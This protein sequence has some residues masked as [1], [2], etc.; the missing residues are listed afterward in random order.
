MHPLQG[1]LPVKV[2]Y[3]PIRGGSQP[4]FSF[5]I[6][7]TTEM[8]T[9]PATGMTRPASMRTLRYAPA[10]PLPAPEPS[11]LVRLTGMDGLW[12]VLSV[13]K[14]IFGDRVVVRRPGDDSF[15]GAGVPASSVREV[16]AKVVP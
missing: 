4:V 12:E 7:A 6:A 11:S 2:E 5:Q 14:T 8:R 16:V 13:V 1:Y 3:E 10:A 15:K 9:D